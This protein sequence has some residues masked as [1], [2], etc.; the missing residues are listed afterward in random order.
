[1]TV[2]SSVVILTKDE[3]KEQLDRAYARGVEHGKFEANGDEAKRLLEHVRLLPWAE[4]QRDLKPH[5]CGAHAWN[6]GRMD[7]AISIAR[8]V[9]GVLWTPMGLTG[10]PRNAAE[11]L[12]VF[13]AA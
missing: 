8:K 9:D 11:R 10:E 6:S 12:S 5:E 7:A 1:M 2:S 4:F 13:A 3:L